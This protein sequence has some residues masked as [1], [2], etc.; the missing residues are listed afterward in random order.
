MSETF[1]RGVGGGASQIN[2]PVYASEAVGN[3]RGTGAQL[4]FSV[5][6]RSSLP[7]LIPQ[8]VIPFLYLILLKGMAASKT[9]FSALLVTTE[10]HLLSQFR[11][12]LPPSYIVPSHWAPA[13]FAP[14]EKPFV[15]SSKGSMKRRKLSFLPN[16]KSLL[17][18]ST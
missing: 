3:C 18:D 8:R 6:L 12:T 15:W 11:S 1:I 16:T 5:V 9:H 2:I 4:D 13:A 10:F 17:N 14:N 7:K